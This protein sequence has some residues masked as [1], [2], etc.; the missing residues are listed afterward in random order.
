[1]YSSL[2]QHLQTLGYERCDASFSRRDPAAIRM[3]CNFPFTVYR[4]SGGYWGSLRL[5]DLAEGVA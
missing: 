4:L 3:H 2:F 5:A 1:M